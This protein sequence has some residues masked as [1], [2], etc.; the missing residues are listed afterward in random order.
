MSVETYAVRRVQD[1]EVDGRSV[2][3]RVDFNVPLRDGE[4]GDDSRIRAAL[5]TLELLLERGAKVLIATHLGRPAGSV[6]P[7]L[8]LDRVAH[9]LSEL[10]GKAVVKLDDCVGSEVEARVEQGDP[11]ELFLLENVRFHPE[12]AANETS[13][14]RKLA[15]LADIFVNDAFAAVH[16]AHAS[17]LGVAE[18]LPSYAGC[19][20]QREL[21]A[22][23]RLLVDP[24]RPYLA[25]VGGKK[26]ASKLGAL[27]DLVGQVDAL[28]IGGGVAF[29]VL[30]AR[31][32]AVGE[33]LVDEGT[34]DE[35]RAFLAAAEASEVDVVLPTDARVAQSL[36]PGEETAVS[37]VASI[38]FGWA[39]FDIGPETADLFRRRI[40][41]A[42]SVVWTGP[43][44]AFEVEPFDEGTKAVAEALAASDAF[45]VVGGG[46]TGDAVARFGFEGDV[47]Y[48]STGGGA[49]LAL[50]RGKKLAALEAL[51]ETTES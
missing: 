7:E 42:R 44:G 17:T 19:L 32:T 21:D 47:S 50:L 29:S 6:V 26:A 24:D 46:E 34:F 14:A 3:V 45:S 22:L 15:A 8:R 31:G 51:R 5:P 27:R 49:C 38:P 12:E 48:V 40:L 39:G 36:E 28:L 2:L 16:R 20:M 33:S 10:I 1:A 9:R 30:A 25:V 18:L 11:G 4:I 41:E 13:F 37:D 43:M 23:S 35:I